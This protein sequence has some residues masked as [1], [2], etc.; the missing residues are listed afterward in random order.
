MKK[1]EFREIMWFALRLPSADDPL[2]NWLVDCAIDAYESGDM[3]DE[4]M[5]YFSEQ[6]TEA[7]K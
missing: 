6:P 3:P 2:F 1:R 5:A 4:I 7:S